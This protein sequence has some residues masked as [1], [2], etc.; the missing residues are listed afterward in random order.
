MSA[1]TLKLK[2]WTV[3]GAEEP[4]GLFVGNV[5]H[6]CAVTVPHKRPQECI[7]GQPWT[8]GGRLNFVEELID[9]SCGTETAVSCVDRGAEFA[10][11]RA[12]LAGFSEEQL[13]DLIF[14][15]VEEKNKRA[16]A[17]A[18]AGAAPQEPNRSMGE[19]NSGAGLKQE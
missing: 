11:T 8:A 12:M 10:M 13:N 18:S 19:Q 3:A 5:A 17:R 9:P 14:M 2:Y 7:L 15:L 6:V 1:R 4:H 16:E